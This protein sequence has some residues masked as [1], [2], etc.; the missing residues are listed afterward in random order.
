MCQM[1]LDDTEHLV[2][3]RRS[4]LYVSQVYE[5]PCGAQIEISAIKVS[6]A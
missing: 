4:V 1:A 3:D 5:C 6:A 2:R